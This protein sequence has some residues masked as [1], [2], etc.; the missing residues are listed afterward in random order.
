MA[1]LSRVPPFRYPPNICDEINH[2]L[3]VNFKIGSCLLKSNLI[4]ARKFSIKYLSIKF[5][6]YN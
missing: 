1:T 6:I 3:T 4:I 2:L 5:V